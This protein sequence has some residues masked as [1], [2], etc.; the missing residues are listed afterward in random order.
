M[1]VDNNLERRLLFW[2]LD[3]ASSGSYDGNN[4]NCRQPNYSLL[5]GNGLFRRGRDLSGAADC[6]WTVPAANQV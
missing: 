2:Q 5:A 4:T 3:D 6:A 1:V